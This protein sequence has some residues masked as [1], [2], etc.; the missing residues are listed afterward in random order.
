MTGLGFRYAFREPTRVALTVG[1]LACA[2]VLTVFLTGIYRGAMHGS[3]SYIEET[4]ADVWV[5]RQ[6]SWNMMRASGLML[7]STEKRI[8]GV[9]GVRSVEAV[10][11]ALLPAEVGGLRRTLLVVGIDEDARMSR[12]KHVVRGRAVPRQGEIVLD[13][14]FARRAGLDVGDTL[15]LAG[16]TGTVAGITSQTNLLVTQYAFVLRRDLLEAIGVQDRATFY[17]VET[18]A[19]RGGAIASEIAS[20]GGR[21]AAYDHETFVANNRSEIEAGFLPV[22]WAVAVLGLAV[23]ASVVA[24]LTY[25]AILEKRADYVLLAAIGAS[26]STRFTVVLQQTLFAALAGGVV[27]LCVLVAI[28]ALLPA[29]VPEVEFR[30][31]A[32][33]VAAAL[34]G[35]A[36][37]AIAG[38]AL[39][40]RVV[41][42]LTPLEALRR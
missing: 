29:L 39:P 14:A 37:M 28:Q 41:T 23:G 24:L 5:G 8:R 21:T 32:V 22:L 11:T 42:R 36:A 9:E 3:L 20:T 12:P 40:G 10:L 4:S 16:H 1:G 13:Q 26:P 18:D 7:G 34:A 17:L 35:A 19:G 33:I 30:L 25:A 27:G 31:D 38:A 2:V 6:G 15:M